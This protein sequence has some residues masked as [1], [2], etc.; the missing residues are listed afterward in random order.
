[1][2]NLYNF[3]K[4]ENKNFSFNN[5]N[6]TL[7]RIVTDNKNINASEIIKSKNNF[8]KIVNIPNRK[9]IFQKIQK[10]S[11]DLINITRPIN[12][13]ILEIII[14]ILSQFTL[15]RK[16]K[17]F[18]LMREKIEAIK[19]SYITK[20][21][22]FAIDFDY[23]SEDFY[24]DI[25][26]ETL[27]FS[28]TSFFDDPFDN[29]LFTLFHE[30]YE[31]IIKNNQETLHEKY[32]YKFITRLESIEN[33]LYR[34]LLQEQKDDLKKIKTFT[35]IKKILNLDLDEIDFIK[36]QE[37]MYNDATAKVFYFFNFAY[38]KFSKSLINIDPEIVKICSNIEI[39][40]YAQ[41]TQKFFNSGANN[42]DL[43][44][45]FPNDECK[46]IYETLSL[47]EGDTEDI[48]V[49]K[50][51]RHKKYIFNFYYFNSNYLG[52]CYNNLEELFE[53]IK[54]YSIDDLK[55]GKD[56]NE[57]V[58]INISIENGFKIFREIF[59]EDAKN[60]FL[61]YISEKI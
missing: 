35:E 21:D 42:F 19:K 32:K 61:K 15:E 53:D 20:G 27:R 40:N 13:N 30:C 50:I 6:E 45:F 41:R 16:G 43:R 59:S 9:E 26:R 49:T 52:D 28:E 29:Y 14:F 5:L 60:K 8:F 39:F 46:L 31:K 47:P 23:L 22:F 4:N 11:T 48:E 10:A 7:K 25:F 44:N 58:S 3:I 56:I 34:T 24:R 18:Q 38:E 37:K 17:I 55:T 12:E 36:E 51:Y 54:I 33:K 57:I 1:M 2:Q